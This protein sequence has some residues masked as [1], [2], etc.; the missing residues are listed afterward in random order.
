MDKSTCCYKAFKQK[1]IN[2]N[3]NVEIKD[4]FI[5]EI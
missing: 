2:F 4:V 3:Y 5:F 1:N